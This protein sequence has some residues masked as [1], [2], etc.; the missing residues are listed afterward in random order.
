MNVAWKSDAGRVRT[1]N[2]DAVLVDEECGTFLL[3][4]GM[5][6]HNAGEIASDIAV[7]E[8]YALIHREMA[9]PGGG[10][11]LLGVLEEALHEADRAVRV[12]AGSDAM[13][14]GMGTTLVEVAV[15]GNTAYLCHVGDSR[16]YLFRDRLQRVTR[17]HT[18][19]ASYVESGHMETAQVPPRLWNMLTQAVGTSSTLLPDKKSIA[20]KAGDILLLCSDGLTG[21]LT[22]EEIGGILLRGKGRPGQ[23]VDRL[24]E[25]A[26]RKG[27]TDNIS[28]I[29]IEI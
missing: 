24:V 13:F 17:D 25:D 26:N 3:A 2:E 23:V 27:G 4:D 22:D 10:R 5:G 7:K 15:R 21:M 6:G 28:V 20:L 12:K 9:R 29:V 18:V 8:A 19:G 1:N 11:D 14:R 16:A